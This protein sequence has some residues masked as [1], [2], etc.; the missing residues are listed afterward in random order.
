M[1]RDSLFST[2]KV[3]LST[4]VLRLILGWGEFANSIRTLFVPRYSDITAALIIIVKIKPT[5][6]NGK[7]GLIQIGWQLNS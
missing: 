7:V 5:S 6:R 1:S 2:G 4:G 3:A